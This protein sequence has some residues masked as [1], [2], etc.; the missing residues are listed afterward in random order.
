MVAASGIFFEALE[1]D[2]FQIYRDAGVELARRERDVVVV[3][4][5]REHAKSLF[6]LPRVEIV[7]ANVLDAT[8]IARITRGADAVVNASYGDAR[9]TLM[10]WGASKATG[11]AVRFLPQGS[12]AAPAN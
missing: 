6:L 3:T 1:D 10:S 4:R 12:A 2:R 9:V 5:A 11:V 8:A 7:E